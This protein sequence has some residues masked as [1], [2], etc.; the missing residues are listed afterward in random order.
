MNA[1]EEAKKVW[2]PPLSTD[3]LQVQEQKLKERNF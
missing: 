3:S 2:S 1:L